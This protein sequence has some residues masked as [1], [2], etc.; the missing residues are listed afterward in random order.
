MFNESIQFLRDIHHDP[1][2]KNRMGILTNWGTTDSMYDTM[3]NYDDFIRQAGKFITAG[4]KDCYF[5]INR[6]Y[7]PK[8]NHGKSTNNAWHLNSFV[9]DYDFYKLKEYCHLKPDE[10]YFKHIE[11]PS[12][13]I[14]SGR[15]VYVVYIF[16][17]ASKKVSN[18]YRKIYKALVYDQ[19]QFGAHSSVD[20]IT[21]VIRIP[22]TFNSRTNSMVTI[23]ENILVNYRLNHF[24]CYL[25]YSYE[26]VIQNRLQRISGNESIK[27]S[28]AEKPRSK[29]I[30]KIGPGKQHFK[31]YT[32]I[33]NDLY[34]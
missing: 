29:G 7:R 25:K 14:N 9:I 23:I 5:T 1:G 30:F 17:H 16:Q 15:G 10:M 8:D 31:I 33:L 13:V 3:F 4:K 11:Q 28:E 22:G 32:K 20:N 19:Q 26:E 18:L 2:K 12:Y 27:P 21:Q 24:D 34:Y 6:F